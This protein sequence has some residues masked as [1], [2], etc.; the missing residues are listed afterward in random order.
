M[1]KEKVRTHG[2]KLFTA[3][4]TQEE[5]SPHAI[6]AFLGNTNSLHDITPFGENGVKLGNESG[7]AAS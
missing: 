7:T 4:C 6:Q 3:I 5:R 2:T 1:I